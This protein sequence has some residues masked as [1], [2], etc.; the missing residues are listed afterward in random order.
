MKAD[1]ENLESEIKELEMMRDRVISLSDLEKTRLDQM[2]RDAKS[3]NRSLKKE[4]EHYDRVKKSSARKSGLIN[5]SSK[6]IPACM[7]KYSE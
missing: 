7:T 3:E 2:L 1:L 5:S 4:L 6:N